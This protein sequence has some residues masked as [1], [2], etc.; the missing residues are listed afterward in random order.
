V[1]EAT[2]T[3][4]VDGDLKSAFS[5]AAKAHDQTGAQLLRRFMRDY[6]KDQQ[7]QSKYDVWFRRQVQIGLDSANAGH[8]IPSEEVE[9]R[10]AKRRAE[11]RRKLRDQSA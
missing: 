10:F 5:E 4:R 9:A 1:A 8:L 3:F 6:V 2:F 7:E 11:T